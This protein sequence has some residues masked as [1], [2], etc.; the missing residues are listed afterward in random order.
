MVLLYSDKMTS[1]N[2]QNLPSTWTNESDI[3]EKACDYTKSVLEK[4]TKSGVKFDVLT[5]GNEVNYNFLGYTRDSEYKG[6][7]WMGI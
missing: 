4:L 5:I 1:E 2:Q 6:W 7:Y 3:T